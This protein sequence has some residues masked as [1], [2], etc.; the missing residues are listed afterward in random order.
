MEIPDSARRFVEIAAAKGIAVD[1]HFFPDG[2]K[3]SADA[4]AAVGCDLAAIAKSLV[5]MA[6]DEPVLIL[7]A[8]DKRVD[9]G[10]VSELLGDK[11]VRRASLEEVRAHT[12]FAAGGTPAFGHPKPL[13]VLAD[14]SL[15]RNREVW[16]ACGTPTTVYPMDLASLVVA[17]DATW[18]D[19][20]ES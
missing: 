11:K 3:T 8:G 5:F 15:R 18:V 10:R 12:G 14:V 1:V 2:T 9:T 13:V 20:A 17:A 19:V 6:D 16:S 4:A 7:M